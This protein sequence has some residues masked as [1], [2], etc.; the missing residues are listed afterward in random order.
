MSK[1]TIYT[2]LD[3]LA[4]EY[5]WHIEYILS[6][7]IDVILE[8]HSKIL[9]RKNLEQAVETKLIGLAT[10]CAFNGKLDK[11]DRLFKDNLDGEEIS[12]EEQKEQMRQL[13]LKMGKDPKKFQEQY[14]KGEVRF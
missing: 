7:P 12:A 5:S 2:L 14:E 6:L 11:L 4:S 10:A 9:K 13:W 3:V 1:S 8:L